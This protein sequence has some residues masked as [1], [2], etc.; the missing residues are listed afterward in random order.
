M[1]PRRLEGIDVKS[2]K[3]CVRVEHKPT[4]FII[5]IAEPSCVEVDLTV[6]LMANSIPFHAAGFKVANREHR[7]LVRLEG[8]EGDIVKAIQANW[9]VY[10][11]LPIPPTV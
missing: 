1:I 11:C 6:T 4:T 3:K 10:L 7:V 5:A 8:T 2:A 9:A